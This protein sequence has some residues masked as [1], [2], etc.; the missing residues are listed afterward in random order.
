LATLA[1]AGSPPSDLRRLATV[2]LRSLD[3]SGRPLEDASVGVVAAMNLRELRLDLVGN[4]LRLAMSMKGLE[5]INGRPAWWV[6]GIAQELGLA[7]GEPQI[8]RTL[9][10]PVGGRAWLLVPQPMSRASAE[11][12]AHSAGARLACLTTRSQLDAVLAALP[13]VAA[14]DLRSDLLGAMHVGLARA[15]DGVWRW[16]DGQAVE[17]IQP[18]FGPVAVMVQGERRYVAHPDMYMACPLLEWEKP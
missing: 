18:E 15:A 10:T 11:R 14:W 8:L 2:P 1:L 3:I 4:G 16:P 7:V 6:R 17:V 9:A 13:P 12:L 5:A